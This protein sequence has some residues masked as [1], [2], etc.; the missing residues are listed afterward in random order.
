MKRRNVLAGL[1]L[2]AIMGLALSLSPPASAGESSDPYRLPIDNIVV[3]FKE[4]DVHSPTPPPPGEVNATTRTMTAGSSA[5]YTETIGDAPGMDRDRWWNQD[6]GWTHTFDPTAKVITSAKLEIRTWDV[7]YAHG[8]RN[9]LYADGQ[10]LGLTRGAND[11]WSYT[12]FTLD[13]ALLADGTLNIWI[14]VDSLNTERTWRVVVDWSRLTVEHQAAGYA[15]LF[16]LQAVD[17]HDPTRK[18]IHR[19]QMLSE[20]RQPRTAIMRAHKDS[21]AL[22]WAPGEPRWLRPVRGSGV[23]EVTHASSRSWRQ[24]ARAG[25]QRRSVTVEIIPQAIQEIPIHGDTFKAFEDIL[26]KVVAALKKLGAADVEVEVIPFSGSL[27][28]YRVDQTG[29]P[30]VETTHRLSATAGGF[31]LSKRIPVPKL[32][33]NLRKVRIG[34][35]VEPDLSLTVAAIEITRDGAR[36]PIHYTG[37]G[38]AGLAGSIS[39]GVEVWF[40][41]RWVV[42]VRTNLAGA[43]GAGGTLGSMFLVPDSREATSSE[44]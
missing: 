26:E 39:T 27:Q 6:F 23:S 3:T 41:P 19:L 9:R 36:N 12:T 28:W 34:V 2:L 5:T 21:P 29:S 18:A 33:I 32:S 20:Q 40:D 22:P 37:S 7:D 17:A 38:G 35:F 13:P 14:N 15:R 24:H 42:A 1:S 44:S 31:S 10:F 8:E 30:W 11:S 4:S 43:A 25:G 16:H